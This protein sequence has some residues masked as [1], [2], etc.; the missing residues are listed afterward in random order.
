MKKIKYK[1]IKS[2]RKSLSLMINTDAELIVR[3]PLKM[4]EKIIKDFIEEKKKWIFSKMKSA[5]RRKE[6]KKK[7]NYLNGEEFFFLG[8]KYA[9]KISKSLKKLELKNEFLLPLK[10][11]SKAKENFIKWY[12]KE[13]IAIIN[14]RIKIYVDIMNLKHKGIKITSAN[15]RWGSCTGKDKLNF[16]YKLVMA[17]LESIDY[18]IV[19]ELAHIKEK[20]HSRRF[21]SLVESVLPDYKKRQEWLKKNSHLLD[22]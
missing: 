3:A 16:S 18:V 22:L 14:D 21:W 5:L 1:I 17:P 9:L 11:E 2:K 8:E 7:R 4:P 13:A 19:H 6:E 20:N 10:H 12:K 15:K